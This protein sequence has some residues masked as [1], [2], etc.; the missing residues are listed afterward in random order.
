MKVLGFAIIFVLFFI[1]GFLLGYILRSPATSVPTATPSTAFCHMREV[2]PD[3][4]CTPGA[5]NPRVTQATIRIT[6]CLAG[7][8]STIR[9]SVT[10]TN[11]LKLAQMRWYGFTGAPGEYEEDHLIPLELGGDPIDPHNLWPE[12]IAAARDKDKV[13]TAL[14]AAVCAGTL[15]LADAQARITQDWR[16][17]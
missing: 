16:K 5:L 4:N 12:P 3:P 11:N 2:L 7:W 10:Y 6:I 9:P 14:H 13:E 17:P 1:I 15:T 8:T